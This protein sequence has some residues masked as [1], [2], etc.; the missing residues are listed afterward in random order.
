LN[1]VL[2]RDQIF[3][4]EK[5]IYGES[6]LRK[7]HSAQNPIRIDTT[8]E[9]EYRKGKLGGISKKLLSDKNQTKLD[10]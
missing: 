3:F 10:F 6:S 7:A 5:N 9:K 4:V 8:V 1:D 2:R